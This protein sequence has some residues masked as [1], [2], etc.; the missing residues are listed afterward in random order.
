[1]LQKGCVSG[2]AD[3]LANNPE[4][5]KQVQF[6]SVL[7]SVIWNGNVDMVRLVAGLIQWQIACGFK[8]CKCE[9]CCFTNIR[10]PN[11]RT[12]LQM[13]E[14]LARANKYSKRAAT[15]VS[16]LSFRAGRQVDTEL[17]TMPAMQTVE[18][19]RNDAKRK[20][21][22]ML[23]ALKIWNRTD[24]NTPRIDRFVFAKIA[25]MIFA[26]YQKAAVA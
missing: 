5:I 12:P 8:P 14:K 20:T 16:I 2:V 23:W 21:L 15:I 26:E 18:K 13:A 19:S 24:M 9:P 6:C 25:R 11:M 3:F 4:S 22:F 7:K 1:M 17:V 10:G